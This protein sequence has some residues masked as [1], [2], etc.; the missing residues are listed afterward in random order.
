[1]HKALYQYNPKYKS[2]V[3]IVVVIMC[4]EILNLILLKH[5]IRIDSISIVKRLLV[6]A[7]V[8]FLHELTHFVFGFLLVKNRK[9]IHIGFKPKKLL[10]YCNCDGNYNFIDF[11]VYLVSPFVLYSIILPMLLIVSGCNY[12][13]LWVFLFFNALASVLDVFNLIKLLLFRNKIK[14][15]SGFSVN[16]VILDNFSLYLQ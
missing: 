13:Y 8:M 15:D 3:L 16:I 4:Y 2:V 5:G 1:M 12:I 7:M 11:I 14:N 6:V 9:K 10:F